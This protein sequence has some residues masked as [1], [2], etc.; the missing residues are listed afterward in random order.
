[1]KFQSMFQSAVVALATLGM[2]IPA[3]PAMAANRGPVVKSVKT[4]EAAAFDV[5]L[6]TEGELVGRVVDQTGAAVAGVQVTVRQGQKEIATAKSDS[7]GTFTV[8][9]LKTGQYD[10]AAGQTVGHYRV[11]SESVAPQSAGVQAL[12]VTSENGVR[13]GSSTFGGMGGFGTILGNG[14]MLLAAGVLTAVII[15]A[16]T[17]SEVNDIP[18]SN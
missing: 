4:V 12:L 9:N 13:G 6:S 5:A 3:T 7:T 17:L 18:K 2:I 11:W 10:V 16:I 14:N 8:A 1:M 15:S